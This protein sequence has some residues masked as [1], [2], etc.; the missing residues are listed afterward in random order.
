MLQS[1]LEQNL[2]ALVMVRDLNTPLTH[3]KLTDIAHLTC[4]F[5]DHDAV[6]DVSFSQEKCA[7]PFY[8][9]LSSEDDA[10]PKYYTFDLSIILLTRVYI[11]KN[12][13]GILF[14]TLVVFLGGKCPAC[15]KMLYYYQKLDLIFLLLTGFVFFLEL[16]GC[17]PVGSSIGAHAP[18]FGAKIIHK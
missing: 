13:F 2:V 10:T 14:L 9:F 15:K 4:V 5:N 7:V 11:S 18:Q 8:T 12:L 3:T 1:N 16:I 6:N 17:G